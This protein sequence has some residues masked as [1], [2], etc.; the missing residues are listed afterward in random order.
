MKVEVNGSTSN[1]D[2]QELIDVLRGIGATGLYHAN[3]VTTSSTFLE[4]G[5]LLSRKF[6]EDRGLNQTAQ[7]SDSND[8]KLGIWN[9]IFID[10]VDIHYWAGRVKG[11]NQ[12][13]PA[14]FRL[15]FDFLLGL[16]DDSTFCVTKK[17]PDSWDVMRNNER[18][19]STLDEL[20]QNIKPGE[21]GQ[22]LVIRTPSGKIQFP[23]SHGQIRLD[24]PQR[25]L[26]S[27]EDAYAHAYKR[28]ESAAAAGQVRVAIEPRNCKSACICVQ[29]YAKY[30]D[31]KF[32]KYF[33]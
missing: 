25:H 1:S 28:L 5:G 20:A 29:N 16:P 18:W 7:Y 22:M 2:A 21:F 8:K 30:P 26:S 13:G 9:S 11:P 32:D 24:D 15:E 27:G 10:H 14:L 12:Y 17:N 6:V 23:N 33:A 3:S 4:Q 19:F 31:P